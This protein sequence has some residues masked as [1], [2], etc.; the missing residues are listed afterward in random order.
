L[1]SDNQVNLFYKPEGE[2]I[3]TE[4]IAQVAKIFSSDPRWLGYWASFRLHNM[5]L[6]PKA[7]HDDMQM[8][9]PVNA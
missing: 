5:E 8:L 7:D 2:S 3:R 4:L 9:K 1:E 6:L